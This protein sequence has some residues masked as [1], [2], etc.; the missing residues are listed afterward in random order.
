MD[1]ANNL[2]EINSINGGRA[3]ARKK[4]KLSSSATIPGSINGLHNFFSSFFHASLSFSFNDLGK[5]WLFSSSFN[6]PAK[7]VVFL[8]RKEFFFAPMYVWQKLQKCL[9][10]LHYTIRLAVGQ[11]KKC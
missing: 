9:V 6:N 3:G 11:E 7:Q 8:W 10:T 2:T 1:P 5:V 4:L